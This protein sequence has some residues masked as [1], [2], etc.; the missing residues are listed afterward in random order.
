MLREVDECWKRNSQHC[1]T[2]S[3]LSWYHH[4]MKTYV[5]VLQS[6]HRIDSDISTGG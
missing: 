4:N 3:E 6:L 1:K 2:L 5:F